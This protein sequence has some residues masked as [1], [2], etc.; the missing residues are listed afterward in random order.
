MTDPSQIEAIESEYRQFELKDAWNQEYQRIRSEGSYDLPCTEAKTPAN[1]NLNRYRDVLPYDH[2]RI[3]LKDHN[4][5]YINASLVKVECVNR[6]YILTQGPLSH[7]TP[8]FWLMIWQQK[9]KGIIMLNKIIE[10]NQL[11]CYQYWPLGE[12]DGGEDTMVFSSVN[13]KV[14]LLSVS[15]HTHYN[16]STLRLT[17]TSSGNSRLILHFHYTTWPDFGVP[18]SPEAFYKFLN[19][20]RASGV[21]EPDVGPSV[22]HCSAGIGRSGTFCLVDSILMM[23]SKG[24]CGSG[25]GK[26]IKVLLD[27]RQQ[28][29]GLIQTHDQLKF[30]YQAIVYGAHKLSE[31]NG[32]DPCEESSSEEPS[33]ADELPPQPPPRTDSLTRS[34]IESQLAKE[35]EDGQGSDTAP[36]E[37]DEDYEDGDAPVRPLPAEPP[38]DGSGPDTSPPTSPDYHNDLCSEN[39]VRRRK[40]RE[41][42]AATAAK[43]KAMVEK[44]RVNEHWQDRKRL[45]MR[46]ISLCV[47]FV[48]LSLGGGAL[49]YRYFHA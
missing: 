48:V 8:H 20:V 24:L 32:K 36:E 25:P 49:F 22:V 30:S 13:L 39:D 38:T 26:V 4:T 47:A 1:R 16:Y 44:Q 33:L 28:R 12:C 11:K 7:T 46:P 40:R 23:L 21:L 27:M 31:M 37:N 45:I 18:Q 10:K 35:L 15:H 42:T 17:E 3:V 6:S 29:M 9:V 41:R 5:S 2:T 34:M 19:V 43:V 14:D